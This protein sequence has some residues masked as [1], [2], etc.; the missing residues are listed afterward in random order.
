MFNWGLH[1]GPLG[2]ATRP[3]QQGNSSVY[4]PQLRRIATRL[5]A[6]CNDA[7]H[8]KCKLLFALTSAMLCNVHANDN[9]LGLNNEAASIMAGGW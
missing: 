2:N 7:K 6:F 9:V 8:R 3:G 1:D 4:A 5:Q